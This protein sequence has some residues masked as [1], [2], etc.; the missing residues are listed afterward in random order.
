MPTHGE[1]VSEH[2]VYKQLVKLLPEADATT[3]HGPAR[4]IVRAVDLAAIREIDQ[5]E[6]AMQGCIMAL[7][8]LHASQMATLRRQNTE[9][10]DRADELEIQLLSSTESVTVASR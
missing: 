5:R 1:T 2:A 6:E 10:R 7:M 9:L 3:L 8:D 4:Q